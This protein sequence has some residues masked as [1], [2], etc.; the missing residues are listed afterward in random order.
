MNNK[1]FYKENIERIIKELEEML[2]DEERNVDNKISSS[3]PQS[4]CDDMK[5]CARGISM[6][7]NKA[8]RFLKENLLE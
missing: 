3:A 4:F 2:M 5:G 7:R 1:A 8:V 6:A